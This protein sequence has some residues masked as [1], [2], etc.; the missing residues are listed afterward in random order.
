MSEPTLPAGPDLPSP[1]PRPG[2]ETAGAPEPTRTRPRALPIG[3]LVAALALLAGVVVAALG[4]GVRQADAGPLAL[5]FAPGDRETYGLHMTMDATLSARDL[6]AMPLDIDMRAVSTWEVT[7]VDADGIATVKVWV[8]EVSGSLN[9]SEMSPNPSRFRSTQMRIAP[10]GRVLEVSG[11][12]FV[13]TDPS[14]AP[15]FP[16]TGQMMPLLPDHPVAPGDRWTTNFSQDFPF[17]DGGISYEGTSTFVREEELHGARAAVIRTEL[18]ATIDLTIAADEL[19]AAIGEDPG[20]SPEAERLRGVEITYAGQHT[21]TGTSWVDV[22]G[23]RP[24]KA[25]VSGTFDMTMTFSGL[26]AL[27]GQG[28]TFEGDLTMEIDRQG[29]S[30]GN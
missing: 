11:L 15:P 16:G 22:D 6:G 26:D 1:P 2:A 20:G 3:T 28:F 13:G 7:G 27:E 24:L 12:P 9:G 25:T 18:T 21:S 14:S 4:G 8:T 5:S 29:P 23:Q 30:G 19:L 17:G 10:D